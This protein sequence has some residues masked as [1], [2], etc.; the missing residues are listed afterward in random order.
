MTQLSTSTKSHS[1]TLTSKTDRH[2][3]SMIAD[4]K[5]TAGGWH[6]LYERNRKVVG[7]SPNLIFPGQR[8]S[9]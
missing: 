1:S 6:A 8:L 9:L 3:L 7:D 2:T 5:N 4:V